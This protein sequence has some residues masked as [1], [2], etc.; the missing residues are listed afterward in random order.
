[1]LD[2]DEACAAIRRE[3]SAAIDELEG[4]DAGAWAR[5]TRCREWTVA[6]LVAHL[7]WGQRLEAQGVEGV[8]TGRAVALEVPPVPVAPPGPALAGLRAAHEDLWAHLEARTTDDLQRPAPMPYGPVPLWLMLQVIA[9]EVGVHHSDLRTALG[10][11]G[12]L[13]PDVVRA[14]AAFLS[15]FLPAVATGG[16]RPDRRVCYRLVGRQGDVDLA[17]SWDGE[18][19]SVGD[20]QALAGDATVTI[21]GDDGDV[22]LFVLGRTVL[23]EAALAVEGDRAAAEAFQRF[24]PGP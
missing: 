9:M 17:V 2:L 20:G 15:A 10:L 13:S 12:H 5:P 18:A 24:V 8:A 14:T 19:W 23:A 3:M 4:V 1:M 16:A 7:T 22:C 11:N 6:G 21:S